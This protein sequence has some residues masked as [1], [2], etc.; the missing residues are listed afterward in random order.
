DFNRA[1]QIIQ[2]MLDLESGKRQHFAAD[3]SKLI[4]LANFLA[5]NGQPEEALSLL[6]KL[7][8]FLQDYSLI[9]LRVNQCAEIA[10]L[11]DGTK[12]SG[13]KNS[14]NAWASL[15]A[16]LADATSPSTS[17]SNASDFQ[18][19]ETNNQERLR[20][21]GICYLLGGEPQK[22]EK[23][24]KHGLEKHHVDGFPERRLRIDYALCL[25]NL[26]RINDA[27][28]A[29][30]N[31]FKLV[32]LE[33]GYGFPQNLARV[34]RKFEL[35]G[36]PDE[37]IK[38]F[39]RGLSVDSN[40]KFSQS[41]CYYSIELAT[42]YMNNGRPEKATAIFESVGY[43]RDDTAMFRD[44]NLRYADLLERSGKKTE[45]LQQCLSMLRNDWISPQERVLAL[46]PALRLLNEGV[47]LSEEDVDALGNFH[48]WLHLHPNDRHMFTT[49]ADIAKK[50][51]WSEKSQKKIDE[52]LVQFGLSKVDP[53]AA[54]Q[55]E[56]AQQVKKRDLENVIKSLRA[57]QKTKENATHMRQMDNPGNL[58]ADIQFELLMNA[59][60]Y[61]ALKEI[62]VLSIRA[63]TEL[64]PEPGDRAINSKGIL[65]NFYAH[66]S[67]PAE[68]LKAFASLANEL[69]NRFEMSKLVNTE[70]HYDGAFVMPLEAAKVCVAHKDLDTAEKI[71]LQ[72]QALQ[73]KWLGKESLCKVETLKVLALVYE[74][75]GQLQK[76]ED[77]LRKAFE[78]TCWNRGYLS[79]YSQIV[80]PQYAAILRLRGKSAAADEMANLKAENDSP[81]TIDWEYGPYLRSVHSPPPEHFKDSAE[82]QLKEWLPKA[83]QVSGHLGAERVLDYLVRFYKDRNNLEEAQKYLLQKLEIW[84][85]VE[86]KC[87][88]NQSKVMLELARNEFNRKD[89][90]AAFVWLLKAETE[91]SLTP[92]I[93]DTPQRLVAYADLYADLGNRSK[94]NSF[95][96]RALLML[97]ERSYF[98]AKNDLQILKTLQKV[99]SPSSDKP[100]FNRVQTALQKVEALNKR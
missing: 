92:N 45:A 25:L 35:M 86:G 70:R 87:S 100:A 54:M 99:I 98:P 2:S 73:E 20:T 41:K 63:R 18:S 22:A 51:G 14:H 5:K 37:A 59:G 71:A 13:A 10:L 67:Q 30:D 26:D 28:N 23:F 64:F 7:T 46:G 96:R 42:L 65:V 69:D 81:P 74:K 85:L 1:L 61:E 90:K 12:N 60:E 47:K 31:S 55:V 79:N 56:L 57:L 83:I 21:L 80:R 89:E 24:L 77:A 82:L 78:I 8:P 15:E 3:V 75:K 93:Y 4:T 36:K 94:A 53:I 52:L 16:A 95:G 72:C 17:R 40:A 9:L 11:E 19:L 49:L 68:A 97:E 33:D 62:I 44:W 27:K 34:A 58:I 91:D 50:Q 48:V 32:R 88:V 66:R 6:K 43:R 76:A 38:L 84:N 29:I 39:E